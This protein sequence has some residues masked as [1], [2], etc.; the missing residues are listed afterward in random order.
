MI[1]SRSTDGEVKK[2]LMYLRNTFGRIKKK[3]IKSGS[4]ALRLTSRKKH[5]YRRL[6]FLRMHTNTRETKSTFTSDRSGLVSI[7]KICMS[8]LKKK[9]YRKCIKYCMEKNIQA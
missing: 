2:R 8:S 3:E 1:S 7:N 5:L 6:N 4:G 9:A